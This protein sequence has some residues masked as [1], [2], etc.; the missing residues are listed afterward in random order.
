MT[1]ISAFHKL[2]VR[3]GNKSWKRWTVVAFNVVA[4]VLQLAGLVI[5]VKGSTSFSRKSFFLKTFDLE[6]TCQ[7]C[8]RIANAR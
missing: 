1:T 6:R 3:D 7:T 8:N 4:A 5:W 2:F